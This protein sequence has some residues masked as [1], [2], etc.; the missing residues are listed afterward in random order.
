MEK[1]LSV[2]NMYLLLVV[3]ALLIVL[4]VGSTYAVFTVDKKI[5][6]P[7]VF[8]S[9]LTSEDGVIDTINV[10]I[11]FGE[12]KRSTL[13]ITNDSDRTLNYVVWTDNKNNNIQLGINSGSSSG[14]LASGDSI[15]VVIDIRNSGK[16]SE[17]VVLG[18][19]SSSEN[20]VLGNGM[21]MVSNESL[22]PIIASGNTWYNGSVDKATITKINFVDSY[23]VTGNENESWNAAFDI[24]GDG[25]LNND[26]MCYL[27]GTELTIAGNGTGKIYAN[28]DSSYLFGEFTAL[29]TINN[30]TLLDTSNVTTMADMFYACNNLTFLDLSN[31]DT[32]NVTNM[33]N[34]FAYNYLTKTIYV[35]N[36]WST[37]SVTSSANMFIDCSSLVGGAGTKYNSSYIDKTYARVDSSSTPGY[38]T[39]KDAPAL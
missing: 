25:S 32:S 8:S 37:S 14:S 1:Q 34:M 23:T 22:P 12:T 39:Y 26:I 24:D 38:F 31:F 7:I 18:I 33:S 36:L 27:N 20:V 16:Y 4:A 19:S 21:K 28:E 13:N 10:S 29:T 15:T 2:K 11:D 3:S 17:N 35:S 6:S 30:L 9:T 5:D